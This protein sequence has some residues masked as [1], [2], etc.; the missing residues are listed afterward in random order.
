M[1]LDAKRLTPTI[2]SQR[3]QAGL[4]IRKGRHML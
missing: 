3:W 2:A 1:E 4:L